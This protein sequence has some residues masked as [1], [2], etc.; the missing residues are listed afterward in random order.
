MLSYNLKTSRCDI[1]KPQPVM[2]VGSDI[3][4]FRQS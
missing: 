4:I 3:T 2:G 1:G